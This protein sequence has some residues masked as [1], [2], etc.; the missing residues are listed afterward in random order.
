MNWI[1]TTLGINSIIV[2]NLVAIIVIEGFCLRDSLS[3]SLNKYFFIFTILL[4][5]GMI[6]TLM[7]TIS[8]VI[9]AHIVVRLDILEI[10]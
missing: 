8:H 1:V 4:S 3:S 9:I 7:D 6:R 2:S 10:V 5:G